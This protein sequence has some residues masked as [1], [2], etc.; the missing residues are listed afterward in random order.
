MT[1]AMQDKLT[2]APAARLAS[3]IAV[4]GGGGGGAERAAKPPT[5]HFG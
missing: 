1:K 2:R 4:L 3:Y 5:G